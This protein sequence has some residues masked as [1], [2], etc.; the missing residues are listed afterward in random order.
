VL[1]R[2]F[3]I[4][5]AIAA[6][7]SVPTWAK[8][9]PD[10]AGDDA[11]YLIYSVGTIRIGMG[12]AFDYGPVT[13]TG[14]KSAKQW[15]GRIR[16]LLGG[17]WVSGIKKP[18]FTG[19]ESGHVIVR[20]LPPGR[21]AVTDFSFGGQSVGGGS[22]EWSSARKF[23]LPFEIRPGQAT[24]IGSFMR[25]P[26]FGTVLQRQLGA[27]GFFVIADRNLRDLPLAVPRLPQGTAIRPEVTDVSIFNSLALQVRE[28][29]PI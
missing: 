12:F 27:A 15:R 17:G 9:D 5:A 23:S 24:Y 13:D 10:Y 22:V 28:P 1:R 4:F 21:Y 16:P 14:S 29:S 2:Q 26:S 3:V 11:G 7:T 18:D 20:R 19:R 25:S 8:A 6:L